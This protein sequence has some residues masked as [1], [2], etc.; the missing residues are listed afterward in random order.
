MK[1]IEYKNYECKCGL[2]WQEWVS[3]G[4]LHQVFNSFAFNNYHNPE[5]KLCHK[6]DKIEKQLSSGGIK[7]FAP[8]SHGPSQ[9]TPVES[10]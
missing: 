7:P 1:E 2:K 8:R 5:K 3:E 9:D 4:T 10:P 6:C